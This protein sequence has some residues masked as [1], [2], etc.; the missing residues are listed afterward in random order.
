LCKSLEEDAKNAALREK[1]LLEE[2]KSLKS[3]LAAKE[4]ERVKTVEALHD[5]GSKCISIGAKLE[6]K[7]E[8]FDNLKNDLNN[9][10][11]EKNYLE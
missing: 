10:V 1:I 2:I 6:T 8:D 9:I 11:R 7:T 4:K 3:Q 5:M